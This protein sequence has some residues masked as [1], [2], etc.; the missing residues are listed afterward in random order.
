MKNINIFIP[1]GSGS[2]LNNVE[3]IYAL[4]SI[5]KYVTG[6]DK[7]YIGANEDQYEFLKHLKDVEIYIIN[8][9]S[10]YIRPLNIASKI[11]K[12]FTYTLSEKLFVTNDDIIFF[13]FV[14]I[15]EF[16]YFKSG[17]IEKAIFECNPT[18][19]YLR[20]L[21]NTKNHLGN[22]P[23]FD[24]HYPIIYNFYDF[25]TMYCN[26]FLKIDSIKG[27][28]LIKTTYCNLI[29]PENIIETH[30]CVVRDPVPP[31]LFKIL[32]SLCKILSFKDTSFGDADTRSKIFEYFPTKSKFEKFDLIS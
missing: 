11:Y 10:D 12:G 14:D 19:W 18:N 15:R 25:I 8:D 20:Y 26:Y 2:K 5:N 7:I 29:E 32:A 28:P 3:L 16:P 24:N 31:Y 1:L 13:D 23:Y 4:R 30:D 6:Y 22:C 27:E 9:E 21:N 17:N